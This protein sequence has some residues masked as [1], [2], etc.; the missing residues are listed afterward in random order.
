MSSRHLVK[1]MKEKKPHYLTRLKF[2][3]KCGNGKPIPR[4]TLESALKQGHV[5]E[6]DHNGKNV[7]NENLPI[8]N[9]W[10]KRKQAETKEDDSDV[11]RT[12]E[13]KRKQVEL[14]KAEEDLK[15]KELTRQRIEK[16]SIPTGLIYPIYEQFFA[17]V[18]KQSHHDL[19]R[20]LTQMMKRHRI[21]KT[22]QATY[23]GEIIVLINGVIDKTKQ[24]CVAETNTIIANYSEQAMK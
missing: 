6:E 16:E 11:V 15:I 9:E 14:R 24:A 18:F 20:W 22:D 23:K 1:A 2:R 7:I 10:M 17:E 5:I 4:T 12:I 8:N 13:A 21:K 3:E 19:D